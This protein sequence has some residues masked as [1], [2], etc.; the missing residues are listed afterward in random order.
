[1]TDGFVSYSRRDR[2]TVLP[3]VRAAEALD[4]SLWLD[5]DDIPAVTVWRDELA[6]AIAQSDTFVCFLS[7]NWLG[8][9]ECRREYE[10]AVELGKRL[11]PVLVADTPDPPSG[12]AALQWIDAAGAVGRTDAHAVAW[13]PAGTEIVTGDSGGKLRLWSADT[14]API[15]GPL[16]T[17]AYVR[18]VAFSPDGRR[19]AAADV[20]GVRIWESV[21]ERDARRMA[22]NAL[23]SEGLQAIAGASAPPLRCADPDSVPER[24]PLPVVPVRGR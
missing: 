22:L 11:V 1:M 19:L 20:R 23:G 17:D 8:S 14:G 7:T 18:S 3:V 4:R 5:G 21:S 10:R 13:S 6:E 15:G 24:T 16:P 9:G 2:D 12:L